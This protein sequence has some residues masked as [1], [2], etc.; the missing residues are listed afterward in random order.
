M[1]AAQKKEDTFSLDQPKTNT[2]TI[3]EKKR[4][5]I[6]HLLKRINVE[7]K[8]EKKSSLVMIAVGFLGVIIISVIFTQT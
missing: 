3:V 6:D 1:S 8:K 2:V 4:P 5:N 7:R